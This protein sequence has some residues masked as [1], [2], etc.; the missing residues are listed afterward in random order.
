MNRIRF[1]IYRLNKEEIN[2]NLISFFKKHKI[3]FRYLNFGEKINSDN[4]KIIKYKSDNLK[5]LFIRILNQKEELCFLL[6]ND[7]NSYKD[8]IYM[9]KKSKWYFRKYPNAGM[10]DFNLNLSKY[11]HFYDKSFTNYNKFYGLNSTICPDPRCFIFNKELLKDH[12]NF[13]I[14]MPLFGRGFEIFI[15]FFC[16]INKKMVCRDICRKIKFPNNLHLFKT[17]L[18]ISEKNNYNNILKKFNVFM[19][20]MSSLVFFN[21]ETSDNGYYNQGPKKLIKLL[22]P[23]LRIKKL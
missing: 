6:H 16:Y 11:Y 5:E 2:Q 22:K 8:I 10:L 19:E 21:Y 20:N 17:L 12:M 14:E 1:F 23:I 15:S 7:F 13:H 3:K 4:V 18:R 9:I